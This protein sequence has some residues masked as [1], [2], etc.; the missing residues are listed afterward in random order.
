MRTIKRPCD[1]GKTFEAP[2]DLLGVAASEFDCPECKKKKRMKK[3]E[4][5]WEK[6]NASGARS[7]S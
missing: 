5:A 1:C 2:L 4:M 6:K 3:E 7:R